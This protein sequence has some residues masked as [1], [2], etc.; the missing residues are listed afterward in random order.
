MVFLVLKSQP[1]AHLTFIGL[2]LILKYESAGISTGT[3]TRQVFFVIRKGSVYSFLF[4]I[5]YAKIK[6]EIVR[7]LHIGSPL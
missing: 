4:L 6:T 1:P 2:S 3:G 5:N 7:W